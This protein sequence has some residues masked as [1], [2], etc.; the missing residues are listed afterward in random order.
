MAERTL[1][2]LLRALAVFPLTAGTL[3]CAQPTQPPSPDLP[4]PDGPVGDYAAVL[5]KEAE[6]ALDAKLRKFF[7]ANC[8]ALIVASTPS[9]KGQPIA[10]YTND[11]ARRW[12]IGD[13]RTLQGILLL[14]APN[15]RKL[16]I[17]ISRPVNRVITDEIAA[18]VIRSD[19]TPLYKKGDLVGGTVSGV[20]ALISLLDAGRET[21]GLDRTSCHQL[22]GTAG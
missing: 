12:G 22:E 11:L 7:D 9:L 20:D 13:R 17:E 14:A 1:R 21:D 8:I 10:Q 5:P 19:M 15:D 4:R 6:A 18:E 16:R 3:A 2:R